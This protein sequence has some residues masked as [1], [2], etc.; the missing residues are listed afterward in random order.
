MEKKKDYQFV[1]KVSVELGC[2][3]VIFAHCKNVNML[4][5][6]WL[7]TGSG[8]V[9]RGCSSSWDHQGDQEPGCKNWK[10]R[11]QGMYLDFEPP[12]GW[13]KVILGS[14]IKFY[15]L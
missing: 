5:K 8:E 11:S 2:F 3:I 10:N 15:I 13:I 1:P 14:L 4:L 9:W 12:R 7:W 6:L